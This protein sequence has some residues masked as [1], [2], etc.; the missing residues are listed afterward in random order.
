MNEIREIRKL[1]SCLFSEKS[2]KRHLNMEVGKGDYFAFFLFLF[3]FFFFFFFCLRSIIPF[4]SNQE[5]HFFVMKKISWRSYCTQQV[6]Y[7]FSPFLWY[8]QLFMGLF[9]RTFAYKPRWLRN[10]KRTAAD[11]C[12]QMYTNCLW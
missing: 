12:L 6:L 9:Q 4:I 8:L 3:L 11:E 2:I 7:R 10:N 5:N 1:K